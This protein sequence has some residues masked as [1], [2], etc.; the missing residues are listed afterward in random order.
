MSY[1]LKISGINIQFPI[2]QDIVSGKKIIETRTY[3]IPKKYLN[4]NLYL[5][6]TPGNDGRFKARI[7]AVIKFTDTF[8]YNTSK[9]FYLHKNK[10][11]VGPLSPWAWT[12]KGKWGWKVEVVEVFDQPILAPSKRGIIFTTNIVL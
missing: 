9:E 7:T 10:H 3:D 11:L 2:S 5:I 12:S 4:E 6:E 8:K 1:K